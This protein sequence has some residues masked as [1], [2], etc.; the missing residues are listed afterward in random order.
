MNYRH[1]L[2]DT[3]LGVA[4]GLLFPIA[5]SLLQIYLTQGEYTLPGFWLVQSAYPLLWIIDTAPLFLGLFAYMVGLRAARIDRIKTA[6]EQESRERSQMVEQL[7]SMRI[8]LERKVSKQVN[9]LKAS[10]QVGRTAASIYDHRQLMNEVVELISTQ[11]GFYHA[12]IF[13]IDEAGEFAILQAANSEGGKRLLSRGHKLPVGKL[14]IVGYV[15]ERGEPRIALDVGQDATFFNNPEL[16]QTRSEMALPLKAGGEI[17]GVLDVQSVE[18]SAFAD[19]DVEVLQLM[20][21]QVA[22]AIQNARLIE[23]SRRAIQELENLYKEQVRQD[24]KKKLSVQVP[25]YRYDRLG[26]EPASVAQF[27][28]TYNPD[29]QKQLQVPLMLR[30]EQLG[31]ILL[32]REE[33]Q[34][35]WSADEKSLAQEAAGYVAAAL[36]NA[37]L[38]EDAQTRAAREQALSQLTAQLTHTVNI[39]NLLK[40]AVQELSHLPDVAEVSIQIGATNNG[41]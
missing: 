23:E 10:A 27:A 14:G 13:L 32:R 30:G 24:W 25:T 39:D 17:F 29:D 4:F 33:D 9:E 11:F 6:L 2:R 3:S 19:E 18:S 35:A 34:P 15:A 26:V 38:F 8:E 36:E 22:L 31:V 5:A 12:G 16:P 41:S 7:E 40:R 28:T 37:R 1:I 21:D 20:A